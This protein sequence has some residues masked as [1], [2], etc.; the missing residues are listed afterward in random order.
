MQDLRI[1]ATGDL[2]VGDT[3]NLAGLQPIDRETG[4]PAVLEGARRTLDWIVTAAED[5]DANVVFVSGDVYPHPRPTPAAESIVA[6]AFCGLADRGVLVVVLLGNHDR[7]NGAA[8]AHA[9]EPM[10]RWRP[11]RIV[12]LD[13]FMPYALSGG[14]RLNLVPLLDPTE[15]GPDLR[16]II[17][18]VPY[19]ARAELA[20]GAPTVVEALRA[21]GKVCG[22]VIKAYAALSKLDAPHELEGGA[23]RPR[24][25]LGHGTLAGA[26]FSDHQTVPLADWPIPTDH[27]GAFDAAVWGHLHKRQ[28]VEGYGD[29]DEHTHGYTGAP[30]RLRFDEA[31]YHAGATLLTFTQWHTKAEFVG[32]PH[33]RQFET[34][35]PDELTDEVINGRIRTEAA[36]GPAGAVV[37][38]VR[39][40]VAPER[41]EAVGAAV[42][43]LVAAGVVVRNEC[44]VERTDRARVDL[45]ADL[46][47]AAVL[48][49]VFEARPDLGEFADQI[50]ADVVALD[51]AA[52]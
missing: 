41:L 52:L 30:D 44:Q 7:A 32:N 1:L 2:H 46:S 50:T 21:N 37:Y 35:T 24:I 26:V 6:D 45:G 40:T 36:S 4:R 16:G 31:G 33:A 51:G 34:L 25:L 39:G 15:A 10:K 11:G 18:P 13:E 43:S 22:D 8:V 47:T 42:R 5:A 29:A 38:R 19:P 49:G 17:Y 27:F 9:L 14:G 12:V 23:R 48:R 28:A 3:A 20:R